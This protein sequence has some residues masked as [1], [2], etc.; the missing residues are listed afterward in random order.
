MT[1]NNEQ[2]KQALMHVRFFAVADPN[3]N[4]CEP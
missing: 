4:P 3:P 2:M 1:D